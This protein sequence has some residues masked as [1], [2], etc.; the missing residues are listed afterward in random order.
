MDTTE[1]DTN[2]TNKNFQ[3]NEIFNLF[4]YIIFNFL[5]IYLNVICT[6]ERKLT[7]NRIFLNLKRQFFLAGNRFI[8]SSLR[9]AWMFYNSRRKD[10]TKRQKK[11]FENTPPIINNETTINKESEKKQNTTIKIASLNCKNYTTNFDYVNQLLS[12]HEIVF[13]Q[14]TWARDESC[15]GQPNEMYKVYQK[16]SIKENYNTGRPHGGTAWLIRNNL[17]SHTKVKFKSDRIS[18]IEIG[19]ITIIGVYMHYNKNNDESLIEQERL[20]CEILSIITDATNRN[21]NNKIMIIGD[22]NCDL[23]RKSSFDRTLTTTIEK[24]N[25]ICLD[26]IYTQT[27]DHTY[28]MNNC[29]SRIDHAIINEQMASD[30]IQTNILSDSTHMFNTSDHYALSIEIKNRIALKTKTR[31]TRDKKWKINWLNRELQDEYKNKLNKN[32]LNL[33]VRQLEQCDKTN[34]KTIMTKFVNELNSII[35]CTTA[36][37]M[38]KNEIK[39]RF[40]KSKTW[41]DSEL[42]EIKKRIDHL[43]KEH[44]RWKTEFLKNLIKHEKRRFKQ[45]QRE[46]IRNDVKYRARKLNKYYK[47]DRNRFWQEI[48]KIKSKKQNIELTITELKD[49]FMKLFNEKIYTSTTNNDEILKW[50]N[51]QIETSIRKEIDEKCVSV[52]KQSIIKIIETLPNGKS[53]GFAEI[54]N[55]MIKYGDS[56]TLGTII[57][58]L[59]ERM[60][61]CGQLSYFFNVGKIQPL[62][63]NAKEKCND[64]NNIRP[65]TVS[66]TLSNIFEKYII[67]KLEEKYRDPDQQFGFKANNST[68]HAIYTMEETIRH[69]KKKRKPIYACA[70]DASK[71]FDKVNRERM[72]NTLHGKIDNEIWLILRMYYNESLAYV[73]CNN[74]TSPIFKTSTGVKQGGPLSPKLFSIYMHELTDEMLRDETLLANISGIKTGIILYADDVIILTENISNMKKALKICED[75]GIKYEIKWNPKKTQI[76]CFNKTKQFK[77]EEVKLCNEAVEWVN[78]FKYLGVTINDKLSYKE[79]LHEKRMATLRTYH[80]VKSIGL[81]TREMS[82]K[83]KSHMFKCYIRPIM[84]YGIENVNMFNSEIKKIQTLESQI[85][86]RMLGLDKRTRSTHLLNSIGIEPVE[87]KLKILKLK[88][89]KRLINNVITGRILQHQIINDKNNKFVKEITNIL[90]NNTEINHENIN[91]KTKELS[92]IK[93]NGISDSI[94]YCLNDRTSENE[95]MIKLLIKA[96]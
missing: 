38:S 43:H 23:N 96:Y 28:H 31:T 68:N 35:R 61:Q 29:K 45:K 46:K 80:A 21:G 52:N 49:S 88:F 66:D 32:L 53:I 25:L 8:I 17:T 87:E 15:F 56:E 9:I 72:L 42:Q 65:I 16:S 12:D 50:K 92:K 62:I 10:S 19:E 24:A 76:I 69:Y 27:I 30:I 78:S 40:V 84:Y 7:L 26:H 14:E 6:K 85:V 58:T 81:E 89:A 48:N 59:F 55:E 4:L 60:I 39:N 94:A 44:A 51:D 34:A 11:K 75:Y 37:I 67:K 74:E 93:R 33:N 13:L 57:A 22:F 91:N 86:K 54:S 3:N 70:I 2:R 36:E 1:E 5:I 77:E 73:S 20:M 90:G 82:H 64:L 79:Y 47:M 18:T 71:A 83:L 63:K 95:N 41:W